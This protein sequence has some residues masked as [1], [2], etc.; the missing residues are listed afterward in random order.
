MYLTT[1]KIQKVKINRNT[2]ND[3][4]IYNQKHFNRPFN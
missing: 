2:T 1:F 4:Q 3:R